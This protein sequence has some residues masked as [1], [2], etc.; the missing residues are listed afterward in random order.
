M[1]RDLIYLETALGEMTARLNF[2]ISEVQRMRKI[3]MKRQAD[4]LD[5][6]DE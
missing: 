3:E 2:L 1:L 5:K 4:E 6:D